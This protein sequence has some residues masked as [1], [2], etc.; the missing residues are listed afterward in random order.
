MTKKLLLCFCGV[1]GKIYRV[2]RDFI[3]PY[4]KDKVESF[5]YRDSHFNR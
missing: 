3:V 1:Y 2:Q 4:V 5:V